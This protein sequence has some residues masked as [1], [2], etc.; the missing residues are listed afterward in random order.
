VRGKE[1]EHP[2][3]TRPGHSAGSF[4]EQ[5]ANRKGGKVRG[6]GRTPAK[7]C[8]RKKS[9]EKKSRSS[10]KKKKGIEAQDCFGEGRIVEK[11]ASDL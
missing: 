11:R 2:P 10:K 5:G 1:V 6:E 8:P 3:E 4:R 9:G 7:L